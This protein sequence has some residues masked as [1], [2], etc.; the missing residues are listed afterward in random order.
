MITDQL[1]EA[2]KEPN[3]YHSPVNFRMMSKLFKI[4]ERLSFQSTKPD[5]GASVRSSHDYQQVNSARDKTDA[6]IGPLY[7]LSLL[8]SIRTEYR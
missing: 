2:I 6:Q 5:K 4:M 8:R 3:F 1:L 7:S